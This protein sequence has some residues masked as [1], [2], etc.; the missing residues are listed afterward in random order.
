MTNI[1]GMSIGRYLDTHKVLPHKRR[2]MIC[3]RDSLI[4]SQTAEQLLNNINIDDGSIDTRSR[5]EERSISNR[6]SSRW[7][8]RYK[9]EA[10]RK[11]KVQ[12]K[13]LQTCPKT[14]EMKS[15]LKIGK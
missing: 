10:K 15:T 8:I 5:E 13:A 14:K 1:F 11:K 7:S 12:P 2:L 9:R 4:V 6:S 3:S